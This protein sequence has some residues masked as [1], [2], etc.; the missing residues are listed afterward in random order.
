MYLVLNAKKLVG[1]FEM[2][3]QWSV[4]MLDQYEILEICSTKI[5]SEIL[6]PFSF[7]Q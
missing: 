3:K 6:P 7:A 5:H 4:F 2:P 1:K